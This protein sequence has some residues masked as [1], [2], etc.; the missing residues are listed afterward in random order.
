MRSRSRCWCEGEEITVYARIA[1]VSEGGLCLRT[2][3]PLQPGQRVRLRVAGPP[4]EMELEA[5][6]VWRRGPPDTNGEAAGVGLR[7][8]RPSVR[9]ARTLRGRGAVPGD[10][11]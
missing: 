9:A 2:E 5:E 7:F 11:R 10:T 3:A 8:H 4:A 1:N 6:V